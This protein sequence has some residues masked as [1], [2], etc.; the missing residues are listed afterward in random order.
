MKL[1]FKVPPLNKP[2][3]FTSPNR[4]RLKMTNFMKRKI[5]SANVMMPGGLSAR[6]IVGLMLLTTARL[7]AIDGTFNV[8]E[9]WEVTLIYDDFGD[10]VTATR[11]YSGTQTGTIRV[12]N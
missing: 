1:V 10:G 9:R 2:T 6:L 3:P 12:V 7:C 5:Q 4:H 8:T 11:S